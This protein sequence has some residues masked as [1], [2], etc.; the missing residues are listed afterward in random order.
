ME[1]RRNIRVVVN[2]TRPVN[3]LAGEGNVTVAQADDGVR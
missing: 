2:D 3:S 1:S